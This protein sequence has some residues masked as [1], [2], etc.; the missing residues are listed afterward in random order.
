MLKQINKS[1]RFDVNF[2]ISIVLLQMKAYISKQISVNREILNI[3]KFII[4][5][6]VEEKYNRFTYGI[7]LFSF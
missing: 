1:K 2:S 7:D 3:L 6:K 5:V 4:N